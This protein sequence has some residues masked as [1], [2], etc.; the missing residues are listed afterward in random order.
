MVVNVKNEKQLTYISLFSCA[1]IGC[2]GFKQEGFECIAT[3]EIVTR[4]LNIQKYNNKCLRTEGYIDGDIKSPLTKEKIFNEI[5]WWKDNKGISDVDV[6][7]ATP[8]CQGMSVFNHKKNAQDLQRNSLV[9]ESIEMVCSIKPKMFVFE[10]VPAFMNTVCELKDG[11]EILIKEA[12]KKY[13][14]KDYLYYYD[15]INFKNYGSNSSRT[16]TLVIGVRRDISNNIS[17]IELFPNRVR[18]KTLRE[19]IGY[20]PSLKIMN[21]IDENDIYH[22]F[23]PYP[24]YMRE[25]ISDTGEGESAFENPDESKR[26]Y[27]IGKNGEHIPNVNKTGGKYTRQIWNKVA[28]SV[29]TRNDQLAS[30]NTI[31]PDDDRVFSIRE[32]MIMMTIPSDFSWSDKSNDELNKL[33]LDKKRKYLKREETNIRQCIGEAVP[34]E[35]FRQIAFSMKSFL[36]E[37]HLTD[38]EINNIINNNELTDPEKLI[39]FIKNNFKRKTNRLD[40]ATISRIAE[41]SNSKRIEHAAY[42]TEKET[43]TEIFQHLPLIEENEIHILEPSVG[44]GNFIPFI[45]KKYS[46]AQK[47]IIDVV[48]VDD[49]AIKVFREI[50]R[51]IELPNNVEIHIHKS[52]FLSYNSSQHYNLIVGNPPFIVLN[53]S[54]GVKDYQSKYDDNLA[55]NTAAFF[56]YHSIEMADNIAFILPKNCLCNIDYNNIRRKISK[57]KLNCIIDFG[58]K[59]FKGVRIETIMLSINTQRRGGKVEIIS[60]I[61]NMEFFQTQAKITDSNLPTWVIY[62]N[63][64]FDD[65]LSRKKFGV[66]DVFR[67]RQIT[68]TTTKDGDGIWVIK[69]KNINREGTEIIHLPNYDT[70]ISLEELRRLSVYKYFNNSDVYII[71]NMTYYPRMAKLPCGTVPNGSVAVIIPKENIDVSTQDMQ[72][73]ASEEFEE[74]YRIARNYANRSLNID[75]NTI[76]YFCVKK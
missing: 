18:E 43:L 9:V 10:N 62:R 42:Y 44:S 76:Y 46:Y 67:D 58:H 54:K 72:Y 39:R 4:R 35:I 52:D 59:G 50:K 34:T 49:Y 1:G 2:Y 41:L 16:R 23:R 57:M 8:P 25:W 60:P 31:H 12:I 74:F 66:F 15:T 24:V 19:V 61:K 14:F 38:S 20:L 71:P 17:P 68:K 27:K 65:V 3:N 11:S 63:K 73:I 22:A 70:F 64:L 53:K 55:K 45:V 75:A 7:I 51:H 13:L 56:I 37:K 33:S 30:Q 28:P 69:S 48:D 40:V 36:S 5:K 6:L 47:L 29:H 32:L 21:D 26:P